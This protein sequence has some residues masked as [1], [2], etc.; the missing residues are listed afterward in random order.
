V[1]RPATR[2]LILALGALLATASA[3][4]GSASRACRTQCRAKVKSCLSLA[5]ERRSTFAAA[6]ASSKPRVCR[7]RAAKALR[8]ARK[9]CTA[10]RKDCLACC[11]AGGLG[12]LCPVGNVVRFTPPPPQDPAAIGVPRLADG[13]FFVLAVPGGQ[14][15]LDPKLRDPLTAVGGCVRA[16][17]LCVAPG[18]RELDDCARSA[19]PCV[20]DRPWEEPEACCPH[21]CFDAYQAARRAG[22]DPVSALRSVYIHDASCFPGL[23]ELRRSGR[24]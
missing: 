14:L 17:T 15:L 21:A 23:A 1:S 24:R 19:L 20:S 7:P 2:I 16:I 12:P 11:H 4:A 6:C 18:V 22:A 3:H 5:A 10:L 9:A 8:D 13:R